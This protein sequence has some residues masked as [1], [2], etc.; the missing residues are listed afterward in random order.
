M[1]LVIDCGTS[2]CRAVRI[3]ESGRRVSETRVPVAVQTPRPDMAEMDCDRIWEAVCKAVRGE[4]AKSAA[5]EIRAV[6]VSALLGWVFLDRDDRPLGSSMIWMD[7][8]G[9]GELARLTD[10]FTEAQ[11]YDLTGRRPA[12]E[13]LAPKLMWLRRHDPE[14]ASRI[15]RIIGLKDEIVRRL[16]GRAGMDAIHLNY[17]LLC[18]PE[19][20]TLVD[21]LLRFVVISPAAL[22][23]PENPTAVAGVT[24]PDTG[25]GL[26]AGLPVIRGT[27]DGSTAMYGAGVSVAGRAVLVSGTTDVLMMTASERVADGRRILTVNAGVEPGTFLAG[28]ATG[29]SGGTLRRL[30]E[31]LNEPPDLDAIAAIPPGAD[32]LVCRP[33]LTGERAPY[34]DSSMTGAI[35]NWGLHHGPQHFYRAVMEGCAFR[36]QTLLKRMAAA[37]LSPSEICRVGGNAAMD[38]WNRILADITGIRVIR[39]REIE[40]TALGAAMF[41]RAAL[42]NLSLKAI[43]EEWMR[44]EKEY[45]PNDH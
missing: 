19:K 36:I 38:V 8:R 4:M 24:L 27:V 30:A 25:T 9:D 34:W 29:L 15:R 33:G 21:D 40:A 22:P 31:L 16:T 45:M 26:P 42:E 37:G 5:C 39:P 17:T 1:Y 20:N 11:L 2:A 28:G 43:V 32:G 18:N 7:R 12:V 13:L 41:C 44:I 35:T 14:R 3:S 6:G 10:H 23:P